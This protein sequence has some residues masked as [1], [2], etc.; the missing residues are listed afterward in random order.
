MVLPGGKRTVAAVFFPP[1][2]SRDD[3]LR[4]EIL[5][6]IR[7]PVG[8][9]TLPMTVLKE[10]SRALPDGIEVTV[11][12]QVDPA[13]EAPA[14]K[15]DAVLTLLDGDGQPVGFRIVRAEGA[16]PQGAPQHLTVSAFALSGRAETYELILQARP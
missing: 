12:Y 2:E 11:D 13:A 8:P 14:T 15:F 5:S 3:I 1:E 9:A 10:T 7:S 4:V 16:I 6:A